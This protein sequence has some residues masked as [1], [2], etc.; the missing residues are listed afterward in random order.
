[1]SADASIERR[2]VDALRSTDEV[3]PSPDLWSRVVHSIDEDR[4]HRRRV[5]HSIG[6]TIVTLVAL[7]VAGALALEDF[8]GG[9]RVQP[10]VLE[11]LQTIALVGLVLTLGPAIRRF[12]RGYA[13]DLW[14]ATPATGTVLLRLL[15][16][17]YYLLF[18]G[19]TL[20]TFGADLD[21]DALLADQVGQT[22]IRI[23]I[24]TV[25][26]GLLHAV[27]IMV[28][29]FVALVSNSTR[30]RTPL[31]KWLNVV[32]IVGAIWVG[33]QVVGALISLF[34]IAGAH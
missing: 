27:T 26:M 17:A 25:V 2:L 24:L 8:G 12:G 5:R 34:V 22:A 14:P 6:A 10:A 21:A 9:V 23:G 19:L 29:P 32:L 15:D 16:V 33:W 28:L 4:A 31:P 13:E 18:A 1:M 3:D 11:V 7:T 20:A 30:T